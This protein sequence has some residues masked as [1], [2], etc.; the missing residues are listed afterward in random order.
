MNCDDEEFMAI[1]E[2]LLPFANKF[3]R[4]EEI[5]ELVSYA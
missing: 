4:V 5:G 1:R 2:N 3:H